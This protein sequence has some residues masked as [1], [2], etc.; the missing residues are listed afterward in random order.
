MYEVIELCFTAVMDGYRNSGQRLPLPT[1]YNSEKFVRP[2][3]IARVLLF[4]NRE[5]Y[6]VRDLEIAA[7][8]PIGSVNRSLNYHR[9]HIYN[10]QYQQKLNQCRELLNKLKTK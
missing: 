1:L 3:H 4:E 2:S 8:F 10:D 5:H 7:N 6:K 9:A